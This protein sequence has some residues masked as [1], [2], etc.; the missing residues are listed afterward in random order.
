MSPQ[1]QCAASAT[2]IPGARF[3]SQASARHITCKRT[4]PTTV[5]YATSEAPHCTLYQT[6][7]GC[8]EFASSGSSS[9]TLARISLCHSADW[10]QNSAL[11]LERLHLYEAYVLLTARQQ[12]LLRTLAC[13]LTR[14]CPLPSMRA[15]RLKSLSH[16]H[17]VFCC[18]PSTY[19]YYPW[20]AAH[21]R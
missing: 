1:T 21:C 15:L 13:S 7:S 9:A 3:A 6:S 19:T 16:S 17:T 4:S 5:C 8:R 11:L 2:A 10:L 18:H 12:M 14:V 20:T